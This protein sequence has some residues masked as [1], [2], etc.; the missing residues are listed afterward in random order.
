MTTGI[1]AGQLGLPRSSVGFESVT[2][3]HALAVH[4][5]KGNY[6]LA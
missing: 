2:C 1:C 3:E 4:L 6:S 5:D